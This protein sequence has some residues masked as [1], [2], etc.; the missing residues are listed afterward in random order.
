[1]IQRPLADKLAANLTV[2]QEAAVV[3][4]LNARIRGKPSFASFSIGGERTSPVRD[5]RKPYKLLRHALSQLHECDSLQRNQIRTKS[6]AG[7][8]Q[9]S[10][11]LCGS[12]EINFLL[13]KCLVLYRGIRVTEN[14]GILL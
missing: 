1:M 14:G 5:V 6:V 8:V 13:V 3:P 11:K 7:D 4:V 9:G 12:F 10:G 2:G